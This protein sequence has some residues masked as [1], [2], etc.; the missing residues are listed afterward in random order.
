MLSIEKE[1]TKNLRSIKRALKLLA[2]NVHE[3]I[4]YRRE[5]KRNI[6][7]KARRIV[8]VCKGNICR[9]AF[10]EHYLKA[11]NKNTLFVIDSCGLHAH[12]GTPPPRDAIII[13]KRFGLNMETHYSRGWESCDL[14]NADLILAMEFWHYQELVTKLSQNRGNIRLL[15]E[16]AP[17]P[18]NLLCN[19]YDPF[20]Q[21]DIVFEKC[22]QQIGRCIRNL[23][24][25]LK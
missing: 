19:I 22:F 12:N 16:F 23:D 2:H 24:L 6:P 9:S 4:L 25:Q 10:A 21:S 14:E 17:F 15:R 1:M 5:L 18:E 8:F 20:G 13:A 7:G 11:Y 3:T